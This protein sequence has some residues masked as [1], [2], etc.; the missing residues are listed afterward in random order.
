MDLRGKKSLLVQ[1][2]SN[3]PNYSTHENIFCWLLQLVQIRLRR[4]KFLIKFVFSCLWFHEEFSKCHRKASLN[5]GI[6]KWKI[7]TLTPGELNYTRRHV[8]LYRSTLA[9]S[10]TKTFSS[11]CGGPFRLTC[12]RGR[13]LSTVIAHTGLLLHT[14][15][16]VILQRPIQ[17]NP[18]TRTFSFHWL[19]PHKLN[20]SDFFFPLPQPTQANSSRQIIYFYWH[21]P[22]R[23][24][25]PQTFS[26]W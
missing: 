13:F 10:S 8:F 17:V 22:H 20:R 11:L 26:K 5:K 6:L 15:V 24:N 1:C 3:L 12:P 23:L 18:S 4:V 2:Y 16:F 9:Y 25:R 14:D 19:S 7:F 21:S